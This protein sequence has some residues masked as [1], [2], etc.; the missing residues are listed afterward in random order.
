[1]TYTKKQLEKMAL[2]A[3][4][5]NNITT[6]TELS[7]FLPICRTTFYNKNLDK[8]QTIQDAITHE[9]LC[10]KHKLKKKWF[11]SDN[12]SLQ[13][14]LYKLMAEEDEW[15]RLTSQRHQVETPS[16]GSITFNFS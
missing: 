1:M 6:I 9:R 13:I 10:M 2:E 11:E 8:V 12:A 15:M 16:T 7:A 14:A 3:I 4:A 5:N